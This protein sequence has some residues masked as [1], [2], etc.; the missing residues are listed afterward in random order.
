MVAAQLTT[1]GERAVAAR[2]W[3]AA[4]RPQLDLGTGD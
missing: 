3:A 2:A 1:L 4:H